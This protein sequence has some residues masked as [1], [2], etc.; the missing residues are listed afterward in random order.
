MA[1]PM[2]GRLPQKCLCFL[3]LFYKRAPDFCNP[4]P[5]MLQISTVEF[6]DILYPKRTIGRGLEPKNVAD[7]LYCKLQPQLYIKK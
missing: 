5:F 7:S 4:V 3:F 1:E 6:T 2:H